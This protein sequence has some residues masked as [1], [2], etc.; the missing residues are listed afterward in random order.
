MVSINNSSCLS[1]IPYQ[2]SASICWCIHSLSCSCPDH[3][4]LASLGFI[5]QKHL[6]CAAPLM[7]PFLIPSILVTPKGKL[8]ILISASTC[9][10]CC[11]SLGAAASKLNCWS[12]QL[13]FHS[14]QYASKVAES[15]AKKKMNADVCKMFVVLCISWLIS[16]V[17][18]NLNLLKVT[19]STHT[20]IPA[21]P[22]GI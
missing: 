7:S 21:L 19:S 5:G 18:T 14:G 17:F 9:S 11:L 16:V 20:S 15:Q 13:Y 2:S 6:T 12:E 8:N 3:L 1:S 4:S 22:G 10:A